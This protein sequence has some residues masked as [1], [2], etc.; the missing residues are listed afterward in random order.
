MAICSRTDTTNPGQRGREDRCFAVADW[1]NESTM[2]LYSVYRQ[3]AN[4]FV[5]FILQ[6]KGHFVRP[7]TENEEKIDLVWYQ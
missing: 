3:R 5:G 1:N 4:F 6:R 7:A 2:R